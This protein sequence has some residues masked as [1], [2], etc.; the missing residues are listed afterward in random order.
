MQ[1]TESGVSLA[2]LGDDGRCCGRKPLVYRSDPLAG[3]RCDPWRYCD[4]CH[5]AYSG[6]LGSGEQVESWG[7]ERV[8]GTFAWR[9]KEPPPVTGPWTKKW[10]V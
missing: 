9:R 8:G 4:R 2:R 6:A 1:E 3:A 5:R 10:T 7:W